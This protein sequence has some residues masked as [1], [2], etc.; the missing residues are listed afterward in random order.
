MSSV[1]MI[2]QYD[3]HEN[4]EK[5][6]LLNQTSNIPTSENEEYRQKLLGKLHSDKRNGNISFLDTVENLRHEQRLQLKQAEHDYYNQNNII[7][8]GRGSNT[9][10]NQEHK[11][12]EAIVTRKPP[13]PKSSKQLPSPILLTEERAQYHMH[14]R[15]ISA[16]IV[17]R[18]DN[19]IAFCPHRTCTGNETTTVHDLTTDHVRK[20]IQGL[21]KELELEDYL[22]EKK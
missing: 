21:W 19:D 4:L 8:N 5:F 18:H 22:E 2:D 6:N 10:E 17:R 13:L 12:R 20:H 1:S 9:Q 16:N 3:T 7:S 11:E 14:N 15:S